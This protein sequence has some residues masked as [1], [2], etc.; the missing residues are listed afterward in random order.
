MPSQP[1]AQRSCACLFL[2][3]LITTFVLP[4]QAD[5]RPAHKSQGADK[6]KEEKLPLKPARNVE[7]TTDEGTWLSLDVSPDGKTIIFDLLGDLYAIPFTGG[8]AK[9]ITTGMGFNNQPRYSPDGNLIAYVSDRGGAE[10]VW[11][12]KPDGT[13]AKQLS[14]DEQVEFATPTWT[15]DSQYV[16]AARESQFP[17]Q[18]FELW[19][20]HVKGGAG[21]QITKGKAKPDASPR[22]WNHSIGASASRDGRYLYYTTRGGFFDKVYNVSFPLSQIAR[23][24]RVTGEEDVVTDSPGSAFSPVISPDGNKLVYGTRYETETGL[25]IRD[26]NTAEEHW[27]KYPVQRDDQESLFTRDFLPSYTF[28]PDSRE[29]VATWGGKIHRVNVDSGEEHEI[30]FTAKVARDLGPDLNLPMRVEEGPVQLRIAQAPAESPDGKR[31]VF[32]ALTHLYVMDLPSGAPKR[33]T[34]DQ[35]REFQPSW[36]PDGQWLA[37]VTWSEEGGHIW[38]TRADGSGSPQQLTRVPAYYRDPVWSPDGQRL[39]ALR[40]PR[41]AH[42]EEFDEFGHQEAMDLIWLPA[43]GGDANF[44]LPAR[45]G[46]HPHFGPEKDRVYVY[47]DAGLTSMRY[48]G[49]DRRTIVKVV[50]KVWFPQPPEKG[51]GNPAEDV[52]LSPDGNW[53]L[54]QVSTQLYLLAVPHMGGEPPTV[55]VNKAVLP[56]AKLTDIGADF[57]GWSA[58]SKTITWAVGSTFLR[59]PIDK[60]TFEKPKPEDEKD[61]EKKEDTSAKPAPTPKPEPPQPPEPPRAKAGKEKKSNSNSADS[62]D[63]DASSDSKEAKA[64]K[65]KPEEIPI[66]LEFP[67]HRPSGTVVLSGAQ[68]ITMHGNDI[69]SNAD[70][71]VKNNRIVAIGEH[72]KVSAPD[73]AKVIDLTGTTIVPGFIDIHPH[74]SEIRRGVLDLQ[75]WGFLAN[76]AYGVTAGRDPQTSTNDMFAYQDMV[77]TGDIIGPRAYSTGPGVF[78]DTDF[79]SLDDAK[80]VVEKYKRFYRTPYLKSY[81]VGN[82]K[83]RQWMVMACKSEGVMP[84]TEGG[85]D[86]KLDLS[87][88]IDGFSGNEHSMPVTPLYNDVVQFMAKSGIFYTPTL[89][90]AYGGP[91]AENYWYEKTEVHDNPKIRHFMPHNI[92]DDHTRRRP[93]WVRD[94]EQAFP[95]LAKQD[96]KIMKAG[97][98]V[99]IG[100]HGQFQGLGYHWEMW[101]LAAGGMGSMEVLKSATIHGAE[102]LGLD[103][104]LGSLEPGKMADLVVLNKNPLDDIRNTESIR[105]VMKDGELFEGDTLNEIW[106]T[107]KKLPSLWWWNEKP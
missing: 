28:T 79:Q 24:D 99:C 61:K 94:D 42:V 15:P 72:G 54:A 80:G 9:K 23:R 14:Q 67:R 35:N 38:K 76:L 75:N 5:K 73:G 59:L 48:D 103:K 46:Q 82:R 6:K 4:A 69:L 32:S 107:E 92:L 85:L 27:L 2:L 11:I 91:W 10:N 36:S 53:A 40:A 39:V 12:S 78:P 98:K 26:M 19:M 37:Y 29:V 93:I 60:V 63:S 84:T 3:V 58:D 55:D 20:Y 97:G 77:D 13:D 52:R 83:Q 66:K 89:I 34:N 50:G 70:I 41:I 101:S 18:T 74:W 43:D 96:A 62:T 31:L 7:F 87:H 88:V 33:V 30:P 64:K 100:S 8:D 49:T 22:D 86:T 44:I 81:L 17:V 95:R 25:R 1:R 56:L 65:P 16:I 21:V 47:S 104:D 71:V 45:G 102:A 105:Y 106:P 68:V 57:M 90:V 51:E